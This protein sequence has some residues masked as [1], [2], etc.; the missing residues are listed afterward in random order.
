MGRVN[1]RLR[2]V[3][4]A[5]VFSFCSVLALAQSLPPTVVQVFMPGG[6]A[7]PGVLR[8]NLVGDK[9]FMDTVFTDSKG[10]YEMPTPDRE[11]MNFTITIESDRQNYDTTTAS[12][13]IQGMQPAYLSIFLRPL[14]AEKM[15][16]EVLDVTNFEKN[17]PRKAS[18]AYKKA[19]ELVSTGK[20][21]N[22]ISGLQEAIS[23]YPE[24]VRAYSDLGVIYM[25]LDR[26]DEAATAFRKAAEIS[27]R[28]FYPR[29]NLG[30]VLNRQEKYKEAVEVL[31]PLYQENRGMLE[32]RLAYA[33]ALS[34]AGEMVEA[35]KIYLPM[36]Q[37]KELPPATQATIHFKI[38][39]GLNRQRKFAEAVSEF[40]KAI[41][42]NPNIANAHM[43]LGGALMQLQQG[44]RAERELLRAYELGGSSV[45]GAQLLLGHLYVS[46]KKLPEAQKAFEQYLKDLP[47]APNA[48]QVTQMIASLKAGQNPLR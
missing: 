18:A 41:A 23:L 34:G 46:Q 42:L 43:H 12:L 45:A 20:I 14:T 10:K 27:K 17:V 29:M 1:L 48:V 3:T 4:G 8:L 39:F 35:E 40:D 13:S 26:L 16:N 30:L 24:Y 11:T 37:L 15:I 21:E 31:T 25:K 7:P 19:M 5:L 22:A 28:F 32:V 36:L 38:G 44:E 6:A 33:N 9:G 2:I 47:S